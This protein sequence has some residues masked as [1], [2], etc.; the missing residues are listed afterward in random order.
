MP[1][2]AA[3]SLMVKE[4]VP[5]SMKS[6]TAALEASSIVRSFSSFTSRAVRVCTPTLLPPFPGPTLTGAWQY[7]PCA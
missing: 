1:A 3:S 2:C 6:W 7:L 5:W 4:L